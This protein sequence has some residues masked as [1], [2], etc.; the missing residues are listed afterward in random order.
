MIRCVCLADFRGKFSAIHREYSPLPRKFYGFCTSV[1]VGRSFIFLSELVNRVSF[2]FMFSLPLSTSAMN[3]N[4]TPADFRINNNSKT[5]TISCDFACR[6]TA[7]VHFSHCALFPCLVWQPSASWVCSPLCVLVPAPVCHLAMLL[8][9]SA[10]VLHPSSLAPVYTH[11][12]P[13]AALRHPD[14][15]VG[16]GA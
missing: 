5:G 2:I 14:R 6:S 3:N 16:G 12:L 9:C 7:P 1:T 4:S 10:R 11:I 13:V 8:T 15:D